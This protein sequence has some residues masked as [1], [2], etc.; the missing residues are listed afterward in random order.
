MRWSDLPL[1]PTPRMLRQFA[2]LWLAIL[3][4]LA[5]WRGIQHGWAVGSIAVAVITVAVGVIGWLWPRAIRPLFVGCMVLT[6]PI[7]WVVSRVILALIFFGLFTPLAWVFRWRGRDALHLRRD[8][9]SETFWLAQPATA[10]PR[11]YFRQF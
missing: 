5:L 8:P 1:N 2:G 6:F 3:G 9:N 7:G 4:G 10:D 11:R